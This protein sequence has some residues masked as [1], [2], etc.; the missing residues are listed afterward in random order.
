[1]ELF[2]PSLVYHLG[3][4]LVDVDTLSDLYVGLRW[5]PDFTLDEA[6]AAKRAGRTFL[7][8]FKSI[9]SL[10]LILAEPG[11]PLREPAR[12]PRCSAVR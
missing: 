10:D 7:H 5:R 3:F 4:E 8:P 12:S 9:D 2:V 1:M 11:L 6:R